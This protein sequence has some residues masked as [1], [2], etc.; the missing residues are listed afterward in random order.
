VIALGES[1][2]AVEMPRADSRREVLE[3]S[4][5]RKALIADALFVTAGVAALL[6]GGLLVGA[7]LVE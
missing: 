6:G 5:E 7:L 4:A 2:L 1:N 3:V